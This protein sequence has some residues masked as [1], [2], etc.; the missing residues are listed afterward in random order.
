MTSHDQS[1]S[2]P[3]S[4]TTNVPPLQPATMVHMQLDF[5]TLA[6][7]ALNVLAGLVVQNGLT[8]FF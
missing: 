5:K 7:N 6:L 3:G 4:T 1:S 2:L 8:D